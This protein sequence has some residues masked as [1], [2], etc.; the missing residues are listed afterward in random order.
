MNGKPLVLTG[1]G[2]H[3][4]GE[5]DQDFWAFNQDFIGALHVYT[6]NGGEIYMGKIDDGEVSIQIP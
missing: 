5:P 4:D 3:W 2:F 1:Q 6:E